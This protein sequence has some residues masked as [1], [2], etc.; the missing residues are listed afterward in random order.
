[1]RRIL[2]IALCAAML[3]G[4]VFSAVM[5]ANAAETV[6]E[7]SAS[8]SYRDE[9]IAALLENEDE[10]KK[11]DASYMFMDLDFNGD[12]EFIRQYSWSNKSV[13][14]CQTN[15]VYFLENGEIKKQGKYNGVDEFSANEFKAFYDKKADKYKILS[16]DR[17]C[18]YTDDENVF[19]VLVRNSELTYD[20]VYGI[21]RLFLYSYE[22]RLDDF[23]GNSKEYKYYDAENNLL[24]KNEYEN[25]NKAQISNCVDVNMK[26]DKLTSSD[27]NKL[28]DSEKKTA[29]EKLYDSFT[30]DKYD[31]TDTGVSVFAGKSVA[32]VIKVI[33]D[34]FK[35]GTTVSGDYYIYNDNVFPNVIFVLNTMG[36]TEEVFKRKALEGKYT[37]TVIGVA[38]GTQQRIDNLI[39]ADMDYIDCCENLKKYYD[40]KGRC[41]SPK[42]HGQA[43]AVGFD[44]IAENGSTVTIA[45]EISS[46]M[47]SEVLTEGKTITAGEMK[48]LNP[49]IKGIEIRGEANT[50][51]V[52]IKGFELEYG[53]G[54]GET[55]TIYD[56]GLFGTNIEFKSSNEKV[57]KIGRDVLGYVVVTGVSGGT[58]TLTATD[59]V[60]GATATCE[61]RVY[62]DTN[63]K[64]G[65]DNLNYINT[66]TSFFDTSKSEEILRRL[67][68][69][70]RRKEE[71]WSLQEQEA[72]QEENKKLGLT[73]QISDDVFDRLL[74]HTSDN[75]VKQKMINDKYTL[76]RGSCYGMSTVMDIMYADP[77]AL[78][79]SEVFRDDAYG[80]AKYG[81]IENTYNLPKPR[82]SY[83]IANLINYYQISNKFNYNQNIKYE[84]QKAIEKNYS[85]EVDKLVESLDNTDTPLSAWIENGESGHEILMLRVL[86]E[87]KGCYEIECYDPNE[88]KKF[89]VL[90]LL[91]KRGTNEEGFNISYSGNYSY[92]NASY[93]YNELFAYYSEKQVDKFNYFST[94]T[95]DDDELNY[96]DVIRVI[97][98]RSNVSVS[99]GDKTLIDN[100]TAV[101]DS[102]L[103]PVPTSVGAVADSEFDSVSD[104]TYY[105]DK[106]LS[107]VYTV[108]CKDND[109]YGQTEITL[110]DHMFSLTAKNSGT[111]TFDDETGSVNVS[112]DKE[113]DYKVSVTDNE[114]IC[115]WDWFTMSISAD[116]SK[117]LDVQFTDD[118]VL[119]NGDN[120]K[121]TEVTVNN[122]YDD[123]TLTIDENLT[124]V[125]ITKSG[126]EITATEVKQNGSTNTN[127]SNGTAGKSTASTAAK[128]SADGVTTGDVTKISVILL[129]LAI[130]GVVLAVS[131]KRRRSN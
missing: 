125:M 98:D 14:D 66:P 25:L 33:G 26:Y 54:C 35:Y 61:V 128:V 40:C 131:L 106:D 122:V 62:N 31:D 79:I 71:G 83:Q 59:T 72:F 107:D 15:S 127:T 103:G 126:D 27:Y 67:E 114:N 47:L 48:A 97:D 21:V 75:S 99:T 3:L 102:V 57:A 65:K 92:C 120:L 10:W 32:E 6:D 68:V 43:D 104:M 119:I 82:E 34:N 88:S 2:S 19:N 64:I 7:P 49:H 18:T 39:T 112:M 12:L 101:N 73:Y 89:T 11:D 4:C 23:A 100:G 90:K 46:E 129:V 95:N 118:G 44:Y 85:A 29:L 8:T 13:Y 70:K 60:S 20:S 117:S 123:S 109:H 55:K 86:H 53:I 87:D 22:N 91:K 108:Q 28:S 63:F 124:N 50:P 115:G 69:E 5:T 51:D 130:S 52:E 36:D 111:A 37:V 9:F 38:G 81:G 113:S 93:D 1:M 94:N 77:S 116:D 80:F 74:A 121:G 96:A 56:A 105:V 84:Q 58:A 110:D 30:Y 16:S 24:S 78:P 45:F 76:W 42:A 41:S 17:F